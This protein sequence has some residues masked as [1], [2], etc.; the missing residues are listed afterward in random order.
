[1]ST[2]GTCTT[3]EGHPIPVV[4]PDGFLNRRNLI[5]AWESG[6]RT[7]CWVNPITKELTNGYTQPVM[8]Q[9][10]YR[11]WREGQEARRVAI[12]RAALATHSTTVKEI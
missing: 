6:F 12:E 2:R 1:M 3:F 10:W 7:A 5:R 4:V 8:Q 11:G 9:A